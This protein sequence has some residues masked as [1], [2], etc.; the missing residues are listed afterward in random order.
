MI[1]EEEWDCEQLFTA[2]TFLLLEFRNDS[3]ILYAILYP[4]HKYT[5]IMFRA[6]PIISGENFEK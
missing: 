2:L 4:E 1:I 5:E 3:N 6:S